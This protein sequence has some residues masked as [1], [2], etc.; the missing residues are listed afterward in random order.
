M[1]ILFIINPVA[2]R[3]KSEDITFLIRKKMK[4][5]NIEFDIVRTS[6]PGEAIKLSR[7]GL[8]AGFDTVVAVGGD[9]TVNEVAMGLILN[10]QGKLGIIPMGTGND[11][12]KS[13]DISLEPKEAIDVIVKG[14]FKSI[15]MGIANNKTFL[16]VASI[17]LDAE[18][19]KNTEMVKN[20][21]RGKF[22]YVIG[23][24][25][26]LIRYKHKKLLIQLDDLRLEKK[27]LLVAVGNGKYY[28]GGM[29]ICPT[30]NIEDD[31]FHICLI[32]KISKLK[33]LFI[34]P[35][36][37]K[38]NHLK[39]DKYVTMYKAKNIVIQSQDE[40]Y[41][42]IDGEVTNVKDEVQFRISDKKM[43]V[44]C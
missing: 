36:I 33:L 9:G 30:A 21:A 6:E 29:K 16:N 34:F 37:F 28:G 14:H 44:I 42:N 7:E 35:S 17:G 19:V 5:A 27:T 18:V 1:K 12:V 25:I 3:N 13:L 39:Y 22:A 20:F 43:N 31:Y 11:L 24:L 41:L 2:G 8:A 4:K 15:D 32:S 23:L 26:T 40:M 10:G 38:G